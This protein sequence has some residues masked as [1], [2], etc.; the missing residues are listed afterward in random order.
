MFERMSNKFSRT[1]GRV[2]KLTEQT[3]DALQ[4]SITGV[5][6]VMKTLLKK[7]MSYCLTAEFQSDRI[8]GEFGTSRR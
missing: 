6:E 3:S 5:E 4:T 7:G 8:E 2:M 1:P